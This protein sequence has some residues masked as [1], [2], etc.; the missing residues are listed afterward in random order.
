M[1]C[2]NGLGGKGYVEKG[3][4]VGGG[5]GDEGGVRIG[6]EEI[7]ILRPRLTVTDQMDRVAKHLN[8]VLTFG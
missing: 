3:C 1:P 6:G 7:R 4:E 5:V 2:N 8:V